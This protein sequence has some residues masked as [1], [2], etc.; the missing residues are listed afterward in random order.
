[1]TA[2]PAF[3]QRLDVAET[4]D[5]RSVRRA[6]ARE[7]KLIDQETDPAEFQSLREA[8]DAALHWLRYR[9]ENT[10]EGVD[11]SPSPATVQPK[12]EPPAETP[13]HGPAT[14]TTASPGAE[15]SQADAVFTAFQQRA[16]GSAGKMAATDDAPWERELKLSLA[17][18]R[19]S[20]IVE[21]D[22]FERMVA[23][24]LAAGW[25]PGHEAL[26]IAAARV[27]DWNNDRRRVESHGYA[28]ALLNNALEQRAM[29]DLQTDEVRGQQRKLI[30]RL[31]RADEPSTRELVLHSPTLETLIARFPEWLA[32]VA[33]VPCI[34]DWRER[35]SQVPAWRRKLTF[36]GWR[37]RASASYG[38]AQHS[39]FNWGWLLVLAFMALVRIANNNSTGSPDTPSA[40]GPAM[41]QFTPAS[42]TLLEHAGQQADSGDWT[43]ALATC[44]QI[45]SEAPKDARAYGC[46]ARIYLLLGR[47]GE[48]RRDV[49]HAA[50]LD[51]SNHVMLRVRGILAMHD[52]SYQDALA[53]FTRIIQLFPNDA[54]AYTH[55]ALAYEQEK[56]P[57]QSLADALESI[58]LQPKNNSTPY[59]IAARLQH[60]KGE[61][62]HVE[63]QAAALIAADGDNP[64]AY[65]TAA[66]IRML[67]GQRKA[68]LDVLDRGAAAAPDVNIP[69][70][71]AEL[72]PASDL[73]GRRAALAA[74]L[75]FDP[76]NSAAL[77]LR[78]ALEAGA[79]NY[80]A[81]ISAYTAALDARTQN[82]RNRAQL[83]LERGVVRFK[84][85]N[86]AASEADFA[87]AQAASKTAIGQN[88]VC[89]YLAT[90][91]I[92]LHTA[93]ATC[94]AALEEDSTLASAYD[95]K[96]FVLLRMGR[97][98][99][100]ETAYT[101]SLAL[102]PKSAESLYGRGL[103]K[104]K[105]GRHR[106]AG[107]DINA[108]VSLKPQVASQFAAYG[109]N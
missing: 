68:A 13:A 109:V 21:R 46:R 47:N 27:F 53:D 96:G 18:E 102:R 90:Q 69:L 5:E 108:A 30:E 85:G 55:R 17:D 39:T 40:P 64:E 84:Q 8:Y 22:A 10:G 86:V 91:N 43:G 26:L 50:L 58:R 14:A 80:E 60:A 33:S 93:L 79:R 28:G 67:L 61:P 45:V 11:V 41:A 65:T 29:F 59:L 52:K 19:L 66:E 106:D 6:Y 49:E 87:A 44:N 56:Q 105:L 62:K 23:E 101:A 98:S 36:T 104:R 72:L 97:Y 48:A 94:N 32:L 3:L 20:S 2:L 100:S 38:D 78:G 9:S 99:E 15:V 24:L 1:M 42:D 34:V 63:T 70:Y 89:W 103:A 83:L 31:R 4:A 76:K 82:D 81:A 95:S 35:N 54:W 51:S 73:A 25:Q 107:A 57:R 12:P 71:R 75:A 77:Q 88:N 16:A 37:K 7:L 92:S 74:A